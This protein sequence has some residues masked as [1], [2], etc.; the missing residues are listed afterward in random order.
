MTRST[1][2]L[3]PHELKRRKNQTWQDLDRAQIWVF[4]HPGFST[5]LLQSK[6]KKIYM[7]KSTFYIN[8]HALKRRK[9]LN[10]V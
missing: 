4:Q 6:N 10:M 7:T 8:P 2:Y 3:N 1:F 9:K 5:A